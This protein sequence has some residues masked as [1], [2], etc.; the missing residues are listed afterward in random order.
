MLTIITP[1]SRQANLP[2]LFE[3]IQFDKIHKWI[4]VYDTSRNRKYEPLYTENPKILEC[5]CNAG[6]S[7][8]PQR[9]CA[10][11]L[12]ED[13][14]V[15]FLDDDNIIH[16]ALWSLLDVVD[17]RFFYTFDQLRNKR[18]NEILVGNRIELD[19]IDT[20]MFLVHRHHIGQI[21]WHNDKYNADG[22]FITELYRTHKDA[23]K[24]IEGIGCYY[25]YL[26]AK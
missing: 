2:K 22:Y 4:I 23:H 24:Y 21:R 15:Y 14:F 7:G 11:E 17:S 25:N 26:V 8:N 3:S 6:I 10:I 12:V 13:G 1:C 20:A 16:P 19:R 18:T 9:N 5:E